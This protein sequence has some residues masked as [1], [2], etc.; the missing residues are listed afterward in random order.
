MR[1]FAMIVDNEVV[2]T[3]RLPEIEDIPSGNEHRYVEDELEKTIAIYSSDPR[4]IPTDRL[5][6]KGLIWDGQNFNPPV[7]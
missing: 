7:E 3:I 2:Q 4:I 1:Y 6:E 5:V